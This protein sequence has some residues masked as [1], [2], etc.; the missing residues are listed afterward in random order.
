MQGLFTRVIQLL[1]N[2]LLYDFKLCFSQ[3]KQEESDVRLA[4]QEALSMMVG[5][6]ANLQG[7]LLNLMEALVAAYITKVCYLTVNYKHLE[8]IN[9]NVRTKNVMTHFNLNDIIHNYL[10]QI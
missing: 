3:C 8:R 4:I 2:D 10:T 9:T 7:A 5:A 6:Y 1:L